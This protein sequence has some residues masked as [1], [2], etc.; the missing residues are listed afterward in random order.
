MSELRNVPIKY[1]HEPHLWDKFETLRYPLPII[2]IKSANREAKDL[3][4]NIK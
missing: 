1:I 2:D 4:W 3:L